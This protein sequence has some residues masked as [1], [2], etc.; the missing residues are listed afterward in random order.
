MK[1]TQRIT[2]TKLLH[3]SALIS[4]EHASLAEENNLEVSQKRA[5][6]LSDD[7]AEAVD[8]T[9]LADT[10][11]LAKRDGKWFQYLDSG[12]YDLTSDINKATIL[13]KSEMTEIHKSIN[14]NF[15]LI[16]IDTYVYL[17]TSEHLNAKDE[18]IIMARMCDR[19][20]KS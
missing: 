6:K 20:K 17:P 7:L 18:E 19:S 12:I 1:K 9:K 13:P 2:I 8:R 15:H 14:M 10:L 11:C 16:E 5:D 3:K 4:L